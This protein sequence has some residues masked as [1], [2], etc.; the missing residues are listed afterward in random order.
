MTDT[1]I[2]F[3]SVFFNIESSTSPDLFNS[4][5]KQQMAHKDEL[6]LFFCTTPGSLAC[7]G[8][9]LRVLTECWGVYSFL[10]TRPTG[11]LSVHQCSWKKWACAAWVSLLDVLVSLLAC[12]CLLSG[13]CNP[14]LLIPCTLFSAIDITQSSWSK[15]ASKRSSQIFGSLSQRSGWVKLTI[16]SLCEVLKVTHALSC[17]LF[18]RSGNVVLDDENVSLQVLTIS[19]LR[20]S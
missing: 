9:V 20:E 12:E 11:V 19:V 1:S 17:R 5:V 16:L 2:C 14:H 3:V 4:S 7:Q 15:H 18:G 6:R 10:L 13:V 8:S